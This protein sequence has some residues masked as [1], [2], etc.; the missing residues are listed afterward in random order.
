MKAVLCLEGVLT[1]NSK[2]NFL[3]LQIERIFIGQNRKK[4]TNDQF[5]KPM[6]SYK[7]KCQYYYSTWQRLTIQKRISNYCLFV[8]HIKIGKKGV[9]TNKHKHIS[10]FIQS[11]Y[12]ICHKI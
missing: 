7:I 8:F 1:I 6:L 10:S 3:F 2:K 9:K 5:S 4:Q 12:Y 11:N